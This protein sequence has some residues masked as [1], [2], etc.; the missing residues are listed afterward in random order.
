MRDR[1]ASALQATGAVALSAGAFIVSTPL[2]LAVAGVLLIA[3][4]LVVGLVDRKPS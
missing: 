4:G 1:I 2:G 3:A